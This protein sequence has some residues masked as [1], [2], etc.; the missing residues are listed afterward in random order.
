MPK[1]FPYCRSEYSVTTA[2][3]T[4]SE[5]PDYSLHQI[6]MYLRYRK[7]EK[8]RRYVIWVKFKIKFKFRNR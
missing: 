8:K 2:V 1:P 5:C 4:G 3:S 6:R 7:G